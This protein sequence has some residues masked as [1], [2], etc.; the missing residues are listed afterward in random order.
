MSNPKWEIGP[1]KLANGCDAV[2]HRFCET[3][4]K[5]IGEWAGR[6]GRFY[7][8]EWHEGGSNT[9]LGAGDPMLD[10]APPP[11]KKV[12]VQASILV[13]RDGST[14]YYRMQETPSG[15]AEKHAFAIVEIDREVEE[16]EGL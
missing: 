13:F 6:C 7:A 14:T 11:K 3:R 16:G 12:R 1:V 8:T 4:R 9:L 5:Y 2:I 10:L 15:E